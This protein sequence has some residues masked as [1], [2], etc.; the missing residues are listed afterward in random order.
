[1]LCNKKEYI[2]LINYVKNTYEKVFDF[3]L[4]MNRINIQD[5]DSILFY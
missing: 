4:N 1:M 5:F 2:N 3:I